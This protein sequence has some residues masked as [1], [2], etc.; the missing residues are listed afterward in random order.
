[1]NTLTVD[2]ADSLG[3]HHAMI[4]CGTMTTPDVLCRI[5]QTTGP[6]AEVCRLTD[7]TWFAI[8]LSGRRY[9]FTLAE[10]PAYVRE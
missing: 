5:R 4:A 1:M 2:F 7:R 9:R 8:T 3:G 6:G 10:P